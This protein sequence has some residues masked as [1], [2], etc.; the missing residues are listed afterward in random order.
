MATLLGKEHFIWR[1]G[2]RVEAE[3]ISY[4]QTFFFRDNS[5]RIFKAFYNNSRFIS[6]V[7]SESSTLVPLA[8]VVV[9]YFNT[10]S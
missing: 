4:L 3:A 7:K 6:L 10:W 1:G 8:T 9:L 2:G 5:T